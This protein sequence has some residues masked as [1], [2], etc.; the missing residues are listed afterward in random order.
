M[1]G[2]DD[3]SPRKFQQGDLMYGRSAIRTDVAMLMTAKAA[4][5]VD[6][7]NAK[8]QQR[9]EKITA[10]HYQQL[11]APEGKVIAPPN[12]EHLPEQKRTFVSTLDSYGSSFM[13]KSME[14]NRQETGKADLA[15][16]DSKD[17]MRQ[18]R[19]HPKYKKYTDELAAQTILDGGP[20][21]NVESKMRK[22]VSEVEDNALFRAKSKFG[23]QWALERGKH[24]HFAVSEEGMNMHQVATKSEPGDRKNPLDPTDKIRS[25]T[26]SELRWLYRHK[27]DPLVKE[28]V[29]FLAKD[30]HTGGKIASVPA[31]WEDETRS[32]Q[33]NVS[34]DKVTW[35]AAWEDYHP[36]NVPAKL[37][38][39]ED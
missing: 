3:N 37:K 27:D 26:G 33:H 14:D 30:E 15:W 32:S 10:H 9:R 2:S 11:S 38:L 21:T 24:V 1:S 29:H 8:V 7:H 36:T 17:F 5:D 20:K 31:P 25:F 39:R 35:K 13:F 23:L 34:G 12:V 4:T 28:Q 22:R 18:N 16:E 6:Q 19:A